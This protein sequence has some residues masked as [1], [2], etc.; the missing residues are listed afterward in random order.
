MY[1]RGRLSD[2]RISFEYGFARYE[3]FNQSYDLT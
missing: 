2:E 1:I 3:K